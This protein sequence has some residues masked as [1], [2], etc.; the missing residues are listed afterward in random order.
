MARGLGTRGDWGQAEA[1]AKIAVDRAAKHP[2][3][4]AFSLATIGETLVSRGRAGDGLSHATSAHELLLSL[5]SVD[6]GESL[7]RVTYAQSLNAVGRHDEARS[8]IRAAAD[9]LQARASVIADPELQ[10]S[11]LARVPENARTLAL[12]REWA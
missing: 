3:V 12:A 5:G 4:L 7:I 6:E 9:R 2:P 1:E 8:A 11:F 10:A